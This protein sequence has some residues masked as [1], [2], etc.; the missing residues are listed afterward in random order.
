M[1]DADC[2]DRALFACVQTHEAMVEVRVLAK[3]HVFKL[4]YIIHD[5]KVHKSFHLLL[6]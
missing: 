3:V 2:S 4:E 1:E 5:W 6:M